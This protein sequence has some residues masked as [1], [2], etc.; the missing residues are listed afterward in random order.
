MYF[1]LRAAVYRQFGMVPTNRLV[2]PG[3]TY[4]M[5]SPNPRTINSMPIH[6]AIMGTALANVFLNGY[7]KK[8]AAYT[9]MLISGMVPTPYRNINAVLYSVP[10]MASDPKS[11]AYTNPQGRKPLN[12]PVTKSAL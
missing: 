8:D 2:F 1:A 5:L 9:T 11:A 7:L 3:D 10:G 6:T 12:N 4:G